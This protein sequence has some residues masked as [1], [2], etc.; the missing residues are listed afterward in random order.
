MTA[1]TMGAALPLAAIDPTGWQVPAATALLA[2]AALFLRV[3]WQIALDPQTLVLPFRGVRATLFEWRGFVL[4]AAAWHFLPMAATGLAGVMAG[5][6]L[7]PLPPALLETILM[8][9]AGG[10]AGILLLEVLRGVWYGQAGFHQ[11]GD[12]LRNPIARVPEF[13]GS[14]AASLLVLWAWALVIDA[15]PGLDLPTYRPEGAELLVWPTVGQLGGGVVP[16]LAGMVSLLLFGLPA[17]LAVL[18]GH[19]EEETVVGAF[20]ST[21]GRYRRLVGKWKTNLSWI[22]G[23]SLLWWVWGGLEAWLNSL[24]VPGLLS[25]LV[26]A[27]KMVLGLAV[28][29]GGIVSLYGLC[30][31]QARTVKKPK[32]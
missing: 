26:G 2:V 24:S 20:R 6:N 11:V 15:V 13:L 23:L 4:L 5:A 18:H 1:T 22:V 32:P 12:W 30:E 17:L 7:G 3:F 31:A 16:W 10:A 19:G 29:L 21:L 27:G 8:A 9:A 28:T 14:V 25:D